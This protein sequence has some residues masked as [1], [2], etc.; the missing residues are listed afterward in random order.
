MPELQA[1]CKIPWRLLE[2]SGHD[3]SRAEIAARIV[4]DLAPAGRLLG[5]SGR[6]EAASK[7]LCA[8]RVRVSAG[9]LRVILISGFS[10]R[11]KHSTALFTKIILADYQRLAAEWSKEND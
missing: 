9:T 6:Y 1:T 3:F 5:V 2:A 7:K 8:V 10:R 11:G 4:W